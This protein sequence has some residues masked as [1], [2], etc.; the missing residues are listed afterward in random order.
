MFGPRTP[1]ELVAVFDW[2]LSTLGDPL[3][4]LGWLF[5]FWR[6]EAE[7][8][9]AIPEVVPAFTEREGYPTRAELVDRYEERTGIAFENEAFYRTFALYKIAAACEM[10][11]AK[12]L[13]GDSDDPLYAVM[14]ERVPAVARRALKATDEDG[15]SI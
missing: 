4:D 5:V 13:E 2:E 14:D 15:W 8:D 3:T 1:P 12:Y 6:D 11:Y 7:P 9:P 10:F